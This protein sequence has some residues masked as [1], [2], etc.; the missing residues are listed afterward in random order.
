MFVS[1]TCILRCN[2]HLEFYSVNHKLVFLFPPPS[3][4]I[5]SFDTINVE[6][7]LNLFDNF[8]DF[9]IVWKLKIEM[10]S[11]NSKRIKNQSVYLFFGCFFLDLQNEPIDK[12]R[13]FYVCVSV[14]RKQTIFRCVPR[15]TVSNNITMPLVSYFF[16][17]FFLGL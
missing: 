12:Y 14:Y 17:S 13:L 7:Y 6:H 2:H 5:S 9:Q 10:F 8:L 3:P 4:T 11:H 15:T 16:S 1:C